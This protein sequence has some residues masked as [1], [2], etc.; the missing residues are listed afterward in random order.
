MIERESSLSGPSERTRVFPYKEDVGGS[1]PSAPTLIRGRLS[2][3]VSANRQK[4]HLPTHLARALAR[5][6]VATA[7]LGSLMGYT[8]ATGSSDV[9]EWPTGV[10]SD[11]G[12]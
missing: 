9:V 12:L 4:N 10:I 2:A 6:I 8:A 11:G 1:I 7:L 3:I 5:T